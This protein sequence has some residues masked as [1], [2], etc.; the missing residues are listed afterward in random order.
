MIVVYISP[1][2]DEMKRYIDILMEHVDDRFKL[3]AEGQSSILD[4][5]ERHTQ[6]FTELSEQNTHINA[7]INVIRQD[8]KEMKKDIKEIKSDVQEKD[9]QIKT[10]NQRVK[11]LELA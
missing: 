9:H 10:L 5:V 8:I 6:Q 7:N 2:S 11:K 4:K 1:M 3:L